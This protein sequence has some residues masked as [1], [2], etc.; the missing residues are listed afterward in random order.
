MIP[1][2]RISELHFF[3]RSIPDSEILLLRRQGRVLWEA[4][5]ASFQSVID[6]L[7]AALR[8]RLG[9]PPLAVRDEPA[10]SIFNSSFVVCLYIELVLTIFLC[11]R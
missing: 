6:T 5:L 10:L 11:A 1:K 8:D 9:I 7:V 4:Y 3:L 2:S